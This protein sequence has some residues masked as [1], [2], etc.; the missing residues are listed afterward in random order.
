MM[1]LIQ[2][3]MAILNATQRMAARPP[4]IVQPAMAHWLDQA[5]LQVPAAVAFPSMKQFN[6]VL[7]N[8]RTHT[9]TMPLTVVSSRGYRQL[10]V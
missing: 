10:F 1:A 9:S 4:S 3:L 6:E 2:F 7:A 8:L 5:T